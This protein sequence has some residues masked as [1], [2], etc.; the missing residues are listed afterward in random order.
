LVGPHQNCDLGAN[1]IYVFHFNEKSKKATTTGHT[2]TYE[3]IKGFFSEPA[4]FMF[5][6]GLEIQDCHH[7]RTKCNSFSKNTKPLEFLP[8]KAMFYI[9]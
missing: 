4:N 9:N 7:H 8:T 6:Y 3:K 2:L 1:P 5:L